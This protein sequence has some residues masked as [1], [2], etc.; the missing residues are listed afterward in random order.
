M[1]WL[2]GVIAA[3]VLVMFAAP[4]VGQTLTV[5][6]VGDGIAYGGVYVGHYGGSMPGF[7]DL[8]IFCVDF[9]HQAYLNSPWGVTV[10]SLG[11]GAALDGVTR[12]G[13]D[14]LDEYEDVPTAVGTR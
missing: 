4:T 14:Y 8:D 10:T 2:R 7:P 3:A 5:T 13:Q 6:D 11:D 1:K 9:Q 12:W